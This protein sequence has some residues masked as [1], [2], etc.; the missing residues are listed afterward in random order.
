M[1]KQILGR[2]S[3]SGKQAR[4]SVLIFHRVLARPDP[5]FP[6]EMDA[7]R[8]DQLCGWLK[9]WFNVLPLDQAVARLLDLKFRQHFAADAGRVPRP[10]ANVTMARCS[11][12]QSRI[13]SC[14]SSVCSTCA[15]SSMS[16]PSSPVGIVRSG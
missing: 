15:C 1:L 14:V 4:L 11:G 16:G 8:F 5:L 10:S 2:L 13:Q 3:P 7:A 6:D 9:S 12:E